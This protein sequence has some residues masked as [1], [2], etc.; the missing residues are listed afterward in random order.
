[1][2][3]H[4]IAFAAHGLVIAWRRVS[5]SDAEDISYDRLIQIILKYVSRNLG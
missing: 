4:E 5:P 3:R 1:M 2:A